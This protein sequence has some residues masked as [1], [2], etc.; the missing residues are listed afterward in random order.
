MSFKGSTRILVKPPLGKFWLGKSRLSESYFIMLCI[1]SI[2][3]ITVFDSD[4]HHWAG[5][6]LYV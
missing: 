5:E 1:L 2:G 4:N 6:V 3:L